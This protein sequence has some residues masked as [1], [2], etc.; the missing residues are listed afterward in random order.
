M[1]IFIVTVWPVTGQFIVTGK[2]VVTMSNGFFF[3]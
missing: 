1:I 2:Q 3:E